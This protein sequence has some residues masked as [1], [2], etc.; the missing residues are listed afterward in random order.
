MTFEPRTRAL[1][2]LLLAVLGFVFALLVTPYQIDDSFIT[3]RYAENLLTTGEFSF[4]HG[5]APVEGFS[6][7]VWLVLLS[8]LGWLFSPQLLPLFGMLLGLLSLGTVFFLTWRILAEPYKPLL[9]L[10]LIAL[11][12]GI[13]FYAVTGLE[14]LLFLA[15]LLAAC[16]A[17]AGQLPLWLGIFACGLSLWVR[18]ESAALP[19]LLIAQ[20]LGRGEWR[21][22]FSRRF[23]L[24]STSLAAGGFLLLAVRWSIFGQ[25]LPNTYFAKLPDMRDG[26]AY[27]ATTL[28][29]PSSLVLVA[30][31][32]C[33]CIVGKPLYRGFF[34]AG[35]AWILVVIAEGGD[36]MPQARMLLPTLSFFA[37]AAGGLVDPAG[38]LSQYLAG[39]SARTRYKSAIAVTIAMAIALTLTFLILI[40][41]ELSSA[42]VAGRTH[43]REGQEIDRL[44]D[45]TEASGVR[46]VGLMDIGRLGFL[47]QVDIFDFA[48]LTDAHI[49]HAS[50]GLMKKQFDLDYLFVERKPDLLIIRFTEA[51]FFQQG[52]APAFRPGTVGS[53]VEQRILLDERLQ[54]LYRRLLV[55]LPS[56]ERDPYSAKL[57]LLARNFEPN[58]EAADLLP[59][60]GP[61]G[62]S[63]LYLSDPLPP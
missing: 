30:L 20:S 12:P 44:I 7:P 53:V 9:P 6:S 60:P 42:Y 32:L 63:V 59:P 16:G 62:V 57:V 24:L 46:S 61:D 4:N 14:P 35:V 11:S 37:L 58:P 26:V 50:G 22:I 31:G 41:A 29:T 40:R 27:I 51:P 21:Q 45:W 1:L 19:G 5:A 55:V 39:L 49:A 34:C 54:R 36:W 52:G 2:A 43:L 56:Y 13:S 15:V 38:R 48:G 28:L 10:M 25:L 47:T 23:W 8:L 3:Y 17:A 33:G 18:P